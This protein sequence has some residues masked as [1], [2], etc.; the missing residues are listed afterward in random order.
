MFFDAARGGS[1]KID[2][3]A[4]FHRRSAHK[5]HGRAVEQ[6]RW[7]ILLPVGHFVR[8]DVED[9]KTGPAHGGHD[10]LRPRSRSDP[11]QQINGRDLLAGRGLVVVM[12]TARR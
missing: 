10:S 12:C 2:G 4:A 11:R 9:T 6:R 5:R 8:K 3:G 1:T 7:I